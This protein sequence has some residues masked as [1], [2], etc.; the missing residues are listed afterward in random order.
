MKWNIDALYQ[1]ALE[2]YHQSYAPYSGFAVGACILSNGQL[3]SGCNVE[4]ACY[5]MGQC[6]EATAIGNMINGG[7]KKIEAIM[8][9]SSASHPIWPCGGCLQ[10]ISEF[11]MPDTQVIS[12]TIEGKR[13][14]LAFAELYPQQFTAKDMQK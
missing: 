5:A 4:N 6:A 3:H 13:E 10:K 8:I 1:K 14:Q 7:H 12:S 2:A 11:C 9:L